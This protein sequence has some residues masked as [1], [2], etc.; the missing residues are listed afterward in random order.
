[1]VISK[2]FFKKFIAF[3]YIFFENKKYSR[4]RGAWS[5]KEKIVPSPLPSA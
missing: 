1:M 5:K 2:N 3:S 4:G